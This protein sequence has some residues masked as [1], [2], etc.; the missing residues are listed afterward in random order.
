MPDV[1]FQPTFIPA[2]PGF[3]LMHYYEAGTD[4]DGPYPAELS[5]D[6]PIIAWMI[7]PQCDDEKAI[8]RELYN[9]NDRGGPRDVLPC[10]YAETKP[11]TVSGW[12]PDQ[13]YYG[14]T[15][16]MHPDGSL[17]M[18][19]NTEEKY[20]NTEAAM[21]GLAKYHAHQ[22]ELQAS[23]KAADD[24]S[25]AEVKAAGRKL[26]ES[27]PEDGRAIIASIMA[28]HD[29]KTVAELRSYDCRTVVKQFTEKMPEAA[30]HVD[31]IAAAKA[32]RAARK[33]KKAVS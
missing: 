23:F 25:R 4:K 30:A 29:A 11:V 6:T 31:E 5:F 3:A 14:K 26:I 13:M 10:S 20:I 32:R 16:I 7:Q 2:Q 1:Y 12:F 8:E 22:N 33:A 21:V 24:K 9:R 17:T 19:G 27:R 15:I 18:W 28:S